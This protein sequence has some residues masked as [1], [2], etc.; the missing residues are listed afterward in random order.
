MA[1]QGKSRA[2]NES[3]ASWRLDANEW[4]VITRTL[5]RNDNLLFNWPSP[6]RFAYGN[7][8]KTTSFAAFLLLRLQPRY[9]FDF[10]P[11]LPLSW[12]GSYLSKSLSRGRYLHQLHAITPDLDLAA[13]SQPATV[14]SATTDIVASSPD[15]AAAAVSLPA[16]VVW[17]ALYETTSTPTT[18]NA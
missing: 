7:N 12:F 8:D 13:V 18:T 15:F 5:F 17:P 16:T 4:D 10:S 14:F 2:S 3:S 1:I 6:C 11:R 9:A